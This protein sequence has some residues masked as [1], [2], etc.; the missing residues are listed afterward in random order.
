MTAPSAPHLLRIT[1]GRGRPRLDATA[2][3]ACTLQIFRARWPGL[4]AVAALT[5]APGWLLAGGPAPDGPVGV[6]LRSLV[7]WTAALVG[8]VAILGLAVLALAGRRAEPLRMI[9]RGLWRLPVIAVAL[10]LRLAAVVAILGL[11]GLAA[12][13]AGEYGSLVLCTAV[14][15]ALALASAFSLAPAVAFCERVGPIEALIES[16]AITR[17]LRLTV[18]RSRLRLA[19]FAVVV[20]AGL[21]L[22]DAGVLRDLGERLLEVCWFT[23]GSL[24]T[25]VSYVILRARARRQ[26]IEVAALEIARAIE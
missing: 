4:L 13:R 18:F 2:W 19:L 20:G 11:G 23:A 14:I 24:L 22:L 8:E 7:P 10:A 3:L 12:E 5:L 15:V 17:N 25:A 6:A 1:S 9:L 16:A 21:Q 26:R